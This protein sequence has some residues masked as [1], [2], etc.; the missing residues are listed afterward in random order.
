MQEMLRKEKE[1]Y[2]DKLAAALNKV[3]NDE[4]LIERLEA[5]VK[6]SQAKAESVEEKYSNL[7]KEMVALQVTNNRLT[8]EN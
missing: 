6:D 1:K 4:I 7:A 2:D 5:D 3:E 8:E